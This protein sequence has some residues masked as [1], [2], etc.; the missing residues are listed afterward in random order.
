M[1]R[2]I[3]FISLIFTATTYFELSE[4]SIR[5]DLL[6]AAWIHTFQ[7]RST[8]KINS[9]VL[10]SQSDKSEIGSRQLSKTDKMV[11]RQLS[12]DLEH[13]TQNRLNVHFN[14]KEIRRN[15]VRTNFK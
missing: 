15:N 11:L 7:M 12:K 8:S 5:A 9:K 13:L 1:I 2:K 14:I 10:D 4:A 6:A 3:V